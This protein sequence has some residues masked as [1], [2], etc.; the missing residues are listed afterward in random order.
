M[1]VQMKFF[2]DEFVVQ[3]R[4]IVMAFMGTIIDFRV[5]FDEY[6]Q[7]VFAN[8]PWTLYINMF[9]LIVKTWITLMQ[10]QMMCHLNE[11]EE[12]VW[13]ILFGHKSNNR[14]P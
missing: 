12:E 1:K 8:P 4:V 11:E 3:L 14:S 9:I 6:F 7:C 10:L 5:D 13:K 2:Q